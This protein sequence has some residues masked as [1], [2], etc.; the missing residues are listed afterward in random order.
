[1][2]SEVTTCTFAYLS[3][4][5]FLIGSPQAV[6]NWRAIFSPFSVL[7]WAAIFVSIVSLSLLIV[8]AGLGR[9]RW[10]WLGQGQGQCRGQGQCQGQDGGQCQGQ[11]GGQCQGQDGGRL[12][13][14]TLIV[15]GPILSQAV[16]RALTKGLPRSIKWVPLMWL[17]AAVVLSNFLTNQISFLSS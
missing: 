13:Q 6:V 11:D 2:E 3:H 16:G 5:S 14:G 7:V 9:S 4:V 10:S 8:L 12:W 15:L 17:F 1:M